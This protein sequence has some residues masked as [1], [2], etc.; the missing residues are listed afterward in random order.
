[1]TEIHPGGII[2]PYMLENIE[3]H[4]LQQRLAEDLARLAE[5]KARID[6]ATHW[7]EADCDTKHTEDKNKGDNNE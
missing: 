3:R 1:M 7:Q 4:R 5:Q 6:D 2:P